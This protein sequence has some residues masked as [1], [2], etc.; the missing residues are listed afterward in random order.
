MAAKPCFRVLQSRVGGNQT[1]IE[2]SLL[3]TTKQFT[4]HK[5][6][7]LVQEKERRKIQALITSF[8]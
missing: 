7:F 5:G 4:V 3:V 6:R 2:P 8:L 1:N